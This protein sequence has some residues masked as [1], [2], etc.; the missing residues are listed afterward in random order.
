M[1]TT[2]R[3]LRVF[4][5]HAPQDKP[6]V[7]EL[8][9]RLDEEGWIEPW[10][11]EERL[12]PGMDWDVEV[13]KAVGDADT[14]IVCIS[15]NAV[16][17]SKY[18]QPDLKFVLNHALENMH[19]SVFIIPL[20]LDECEIPRHVQPWQY[21]DF[22]VLNKREQVYKRLVKSL[23]I[24]ASLDPSIIVRNRSAHIV[25]SEDS[26]DKSASVPDVLKQFEFIKIPRGKFLMGSK[27]SNQLAVEDE[28]PYD[29]W[30]S[31]YPIT[32][33][34]FGEFAIANKHTDVL[35]GDWRTK[36]SQPAT[37]VSWHNA[38]TY[39]NWLIKVFGKE[40]DQ[41]LV[42]R[43]PTEAEWE[44]AAR[45]D[46]GREWPWGNESLDQLITRELSY[47]A[48][49]P[50]H[51]E[52]NDDFSGS[53]EVSDFFAKVF[54]FDKKEIFKVNGTVKPE[55]TARW[56]FKSKVDYEELEKKIAV[57]R[58][59]KPDIVD[60]GSFSPLTDSPYKVGDMM[61][62]IIEWTQSLYAPYPY[63]AQD[64]RESLGGDGKR[65]LR[66]L[67]T[68]GKERFSVRSAK[69]FSAH[70][71]EKDRLL[72]FRIVIAPPTS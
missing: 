70:P 31:R 40:L 36:L 26:Q 28:I 46:F 54:R 17:E 67:F 34:Q 7:R 11:D 33:E 52:D 18:V 19:R 30:I 55:T 59:F 32:N 44:R 37:N 14:I 49:R 29:Y 58:F 8:Y 68:P 56:K 72:G 35:L 24:K 21:Y 43:L 5:C 64:G 3:K 57:L 69:R 41:G 15:K 2:D 61:G 47:I 13:E 9:D 23:E 51:E 63:D 16:T 1:P 27:V 71:N 38:V 60:A 10:L 39:V 66:G 25:S 50:I 42:F 65:V 22:S 20:R 62:N 53:N 12:L 4:L 45:G 6:I 48:N